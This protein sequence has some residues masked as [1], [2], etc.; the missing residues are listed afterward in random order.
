VRVGMGWAVAG[1]ALAVAR[2]AYDYVYVSSK[3]TDHQIRLMSWIGTVVMLP[4]WGWCLWRVRQMSRS[5][6]KMGL[7]VWLVLVVVVVL[8]S[9]ILR[10]AGISN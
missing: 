5:A 10:L 3:L 2:L 4:L 8:F 9:W 6:I 7:L 1:A